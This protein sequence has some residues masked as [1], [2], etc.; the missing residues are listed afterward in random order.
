MK[1]PGGVKSCHGKGREERER[2]KKKRKE[3]KEKKGSKEND[4]KSRSG[5][6]EKVEFYSII[7]TAAQGS[8][9]RRF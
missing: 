5:V 8:I 3:K 2:E 6:H 9:A 4:W 1:L 7:G